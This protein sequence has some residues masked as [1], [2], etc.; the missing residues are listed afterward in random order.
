MLALAYEQQLRDISSGAATEKA[1]ERIV[2]RSGGGVHNGA[3]GR[4]LPHRRLSVGARLM[5]EWRGKTLV[6][7]VV[8]G[9]FLFEGK[10]YRSL[11]KI[12]RV[13]TGVQRNGP[14]FFGL[15]EGG[16]GE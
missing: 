13:A 14:S 12:A 5:R 9:G 4:P 7:D 16:R 8:E 15:R 6:V 2:A 10:T 1:I 11:S 3:V